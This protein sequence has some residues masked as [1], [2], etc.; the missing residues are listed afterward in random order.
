MRP[1][2]PAFAYNKHVIETVCGEPLAPGAV[3]VTPP[4]CVIC[5]TVICVEA[6]APSVPPV[7]LSK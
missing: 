4:F 7:A 5:L 6:P 1:V 3:N 2:A